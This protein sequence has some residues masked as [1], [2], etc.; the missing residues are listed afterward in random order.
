MP[1]P[2]PFFMTKP[3]I[4]IGPAATPVI[5][6]QCAA[7]HVALTPEQDSS[8][9]PTY[10]GNFTSYG[11][12]KWTLTVTVLQSFGADGVWTKLRP[13]VGTSQPFRLLPDGDAVPSVDNPAQTGTAIVKA[14]P[15]WDGGV[16]EPAE[17]DIELTVQGD[18][19]EDVTG[20]LGAQSAAVRE[21][22]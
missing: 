16:N 15:F 1:D 11:A 6:L 13:V 22:A 10:C 12:I 14:F 17:I 9:Y 4:I 20:T 5:E 21:A 18:L 7:N 2:V 19:V 8:D 3:S